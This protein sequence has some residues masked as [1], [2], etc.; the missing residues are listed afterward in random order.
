MVKLCARPMEIDRRHLSI[1]HSIGWL[2]GLQS[3]P[4]GI[5]ASGLHLG[6]DGILVDELISLSPGWASP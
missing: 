6:S 2:G 1:T 3:H 4:S 5:L